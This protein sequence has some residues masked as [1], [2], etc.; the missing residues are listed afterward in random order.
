MPAPTLDTWALVLAGGDGGRLQQ[1]T[2]TDAGE[3]SNHSGSRGGA[4]I[5]IIRQ[6]IE[7]QLSLH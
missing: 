1:L 4:A 7:K 3:A 5:A 6:Y 2:T